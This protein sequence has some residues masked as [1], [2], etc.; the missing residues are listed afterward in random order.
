VIQSNQQDHSAPILIQFFV[1]AFAFFSYGDGNTVDNTHTVYWYICQM[2]KKKDVV[3]LATF[4]Y[5]HKYKY[6]IF[7]PTSRA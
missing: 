5:T 6:G 2:K 3:K 4:T 1:P 7:I